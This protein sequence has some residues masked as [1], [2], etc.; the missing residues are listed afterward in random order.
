M[1]NN[2][3][4]NGIFSTRSSVVEKTAKL[5]PQLRLFYLNKNGIDLSQTL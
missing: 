1:K 2:Y 5:F 3:F 4:F